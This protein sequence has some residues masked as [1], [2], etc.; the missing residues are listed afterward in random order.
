MRFRRAG[1]GEYE[2]SFHEFELCGMQA[3]ISM[4]SCV[5]ELPHEPRNMSTKQSFLK[6]CDCATLAAITSS[7]IDD[8]RTSSSRY[9]SVWQQSCFRSCRL[10]LQTYAGS[11]EFECAAE[12]WNQSYYNWVSAEVHYQSTGCTLILT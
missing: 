12:L 4:V 9:R 10:C 1:W 5:D 11:V 2:K 8:I 7:V 6:H 3:M